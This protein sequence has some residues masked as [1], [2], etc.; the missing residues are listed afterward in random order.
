MR[1]SAAYGK[2][3]KVA[4]TVCRTLLGAVFVFSGFVKAVDPWGTAI[5]MGD[6]F[7]VYGLEALQPAAMTLAI[8][9]CGVELVTGLMLLCG[10]RVRLA[11]IAALVFMT[12]FTI[13][14]L[15]SATSLPVEDCGCFGDAVKLS[16]WATFAKNMV[17]L[18]L[19]VVVWW[20]SRGDRIFAFTRRELLLT[21]IFMAAGMGIGIYCY[22]HLPLIDFLPYKVGVD[23]REARQRNLDLEVGE[24]TVECRNLATGEHRE[25]ALDDAEWQDAEV[26][27][28]V[29]THTSKADFG[30]NAASMLDDFAVRDAEGDATEAILGAEGVIHL[31]CVTELSGIPSECERR[32]GRLA[33]R[34]AAEGAGVVCLTPDRLD[35]VTYRTFAGS[36]PVRCYNIDATVMKTMLRARNG[37]VTLR[38]GTIVDKRNC[39]DI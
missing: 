32:M 11:S 17:L 15:L 39:R 28:W 25:F 6:Y 29:D 33:E 27:E 7:A 19:A 35:K 26:W 14:T 36:G 13:I 8:V 23:I 12:G 16:P 4:V 10:V 24:V 2:W 3:L 22:R 30:V 38:D 1:G 21:S 37:L 31:L 20:F 9:L 34:A 18:P 5:K